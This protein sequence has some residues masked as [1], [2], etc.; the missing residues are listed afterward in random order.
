M[1]E[2]TAFAERLAAA[3]RSAG[4]EPRPA[5][6]E[7]EFN[8]RYWGK[9]VTLQGVRR[10]LC[11][12]TLPKQEKLQVLAEWLGIEPQ[13]LRYGEAAGL[14]I[15]EARG[16]WEASISGEERQVL[17]HYLALPVAQRKVVAQVIEAFSHAYGTHPDESDEASKER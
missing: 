8:L 5:V 10:W 15:R 11:G 13:A 7:R 9:P 17:Q 1:N 4:Y 3:M 6:L 16:R 14:R 2:K 12:E